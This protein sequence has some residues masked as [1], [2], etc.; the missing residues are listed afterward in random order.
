MTYCVNHPQ[1]PANVTAEHVYGVVNAQQNV[2]S[3]HSICVPGQQLPCSAFN[4]GT[5]QTTC[6]GL[7]VGGRIAFEPNPGA[8]VTA[9]CS[10][11]S[12]TGTCYELA[13]DVVTFMHSKNDDSYSHE[14]GGNYAPP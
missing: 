1:A 9:V 11:G 5:F 3:F 14:D 8:D 10:P 12:S 7:V 13:T 4:N 2:V 6:C